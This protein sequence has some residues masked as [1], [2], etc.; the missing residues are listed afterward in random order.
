MT[1]VLRISEIEHRLAQFMAEFGPKW[2]YEVPR[3][4][5]AMARAKPAAVKPASG[6]SDDLSHSI[7]QVLVA[8]QSMHEQGNDSEVIDLLTALQR[9]VE[10]HRIEDEQNPAAVKGAR[11]SAVDRPRAITEEIRDRT[12]KNTGRRLA[13]PED[14]GSGMG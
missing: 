6:G 3:A 4:V 11:S 10:R 12:Q 8:A 13:E 1:E 2:G 9:S 14:L 5:K 7:G